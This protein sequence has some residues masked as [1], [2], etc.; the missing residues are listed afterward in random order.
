[1]SN[2]KLP[3]YCRLIYM[4]SGFT[5]SVVSVS[6]SSLVSILSRSTREVNDVPITKRPHKRLRAVFGPHR[7]VI[8][9]CGFEDHFVHDLR[10]AHGVGIW[11]WT[12]ILKY[13]ARC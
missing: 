1:M 2:Q 7:F 12:L 10:H 5:Y 13:A 3:R 8:E 9:G 6:G 4:C 11:A